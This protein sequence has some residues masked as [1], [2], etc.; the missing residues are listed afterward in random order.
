MSIESG[1]TQ[2]ITGA[3]SALIDDRCYLMRLPQD[4]ILPA[5]R[6]QRITT[7]R[8]TTHDQDHTGLVEVTFQF[9][10]YADNFT[11]ILNVTNALRS[12]LAGYK[13]IMDDTEVQA[14]LPD[15]E[16][17][18]FEPDHDTFRKIIDYRIFY[19]E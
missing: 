10:V 7:P 15:G 8:H 6:Y 5:I 16:R 14:C 18:D 19:K 2:T 3:L 4:A 12:A 11:D 1:L 13:G 9:D 17:D